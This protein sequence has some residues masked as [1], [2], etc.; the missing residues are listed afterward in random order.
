M[1]YKTLLII[2]LPFFI[3]AQGPQ[4][5]SFQAVMRNSSNTIISRQAIGL[6]ISVVQGSASGSSVY[7]E[8]QNTTTD[9]N[10]LISLEIGSGDNIQGHLDQ[11]N[12]GLGPYF[13]KTEADP[14]GGTDFSITGTSQL[15]SVPYALYSNNGPA[16]LQ[17]P[18]GADG[19]P[20]G[21]GATGASGLTG[22]TG[23][24]GER[25]AQG[26]IGLQGVAGIVGPTGPTG[27]AGP[28][29]TTGLT[30]A[31]GERGAQGLIGLQG[32][33]GLPVPS[34]GATGATGETG[35]TGL[36]GAAGVDGPAG[37]NG[38]AG[39]TGPAG[40]DGTN[41]GEPTVSFGTTSQYYRG[42]KSWQ[43]LN[44]AAVGLG[45]VEN[46]NDA[47]KIISSATQT[48]LNLKSNLISPT[49]TGIPLAT[50]ASLGTNTSQIAT[51]EFVLANSN[52]SISG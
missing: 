42:D 12:W 30:G 26:L 48:A 2:S 47:A 41:N 44:S 16:G 24:L 21:I 40:L 34:G 46:T 18:A 35:P 3:L 10:G 43:T 51:T 6:R 23:A 22:L 13:I 19:L 17:G 50:T 25:G 28:T 14:L 33:A 15:L 39:Q 7:S 52:Q 20:G 27:E 49:F 31:Q 8:T 4:K 45:N 32:V 1:L 5:M 38:A 11:I 37:L 29:G 9:I 36:T